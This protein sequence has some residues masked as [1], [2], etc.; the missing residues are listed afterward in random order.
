MA[1]TLN[2]SSQWISGTSLADLDS[3]SGTIFVLCRTTA[4]T[5]G[6]RVISFTSASNNFCLNITGTANQIYAGWTSGTVSLPAGA[7]SQYSYGSS[8]LNIWCAVAATWSGGVRGVTY[9]NG[10]LASENI[11]VG[12][13]ANATNTYQIGRR[14]S[15]NYLTGG[16]AE[17]AF[18]NRSL[19]AGEMAG[20]TKGP[21]SPKYF[22]P[23]V[24]IPL[25][26]NVN[27]LRGTATASLN[28]S[29]SLGS[30]PRIFV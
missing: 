15:G 22:R 20:I 3:G 30:H 2:G 27:D 29:P 16:V 14:S 21:F 25:I 4:A 8:L 26:G 23:T 18:F 7:T 24:Y 9:V 1:Y 12:I 13:A 6:Q 5:A 10:V 19:T 28:G 17:Y 11:P